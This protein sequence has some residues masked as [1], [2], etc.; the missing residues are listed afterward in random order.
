[1]I[2]NPNIINKHRIKRIA[3]SSQTKSVTGITNLEEQ[4][5]TGLVRRILIDYFN[6]KEFKYWYIPRLSL[7]CRLDF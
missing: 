4:D 7:G 3:Q 6:K 1:M 2:K 5:R